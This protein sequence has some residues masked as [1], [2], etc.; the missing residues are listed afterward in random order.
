M[1]ACFRVPLLTLMLL[2]FLAPPALAASARKAPADAVSVQQLR[3]EDVRVGNSSARQDIHC[4]QITEGQWNGE[5]LGGV[6][7]V[8]VQQI[9]EDGRRMVSGLYVSAFATAAQRKA[10]VDAIADGHP[11][12]FPNRDSAS[13]RIE[14]AVIEIEQGPGDSLVLHIA[15][16]A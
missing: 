14:P 7:V 15:L 2:A 9:S 12:L 6:S 1:V 11:T 10:A 4:W 13:D 3:I 16:V 5:N 8:L